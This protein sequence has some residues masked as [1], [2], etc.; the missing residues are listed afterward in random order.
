MDEKNVEEERHMKKLAPLILL[1]GAVLIGTALLQL[2]Q[3]HQ[4]QKESLAAVKEKITG[5]KL[6]ESDNTGIAA[7][8]FR[9]KWEKPLASSSFQS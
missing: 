7:K 1:C 6:N 4:L 5:E 8:R 3:T 9:R 2:F